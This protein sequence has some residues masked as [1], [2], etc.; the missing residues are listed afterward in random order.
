MKGLVA[1]VT[2]AAGSLGRA[3]VNKFI[4]DGMKVV[5]FDIQPYVENPLHDESAYLRSHYSENRREFDK[6]K[7]P[8]RTKQ[9]EK[10]ETLETLN[11]TEKS[12]NSLF[13]DFESKNIQGNRYFAREYFGK[14]NLSLNDASVE[15]S[16]VKESEAQSTSDNDDKPFFQGQNYDNCVEVNGD[17]TSSDNVTDAIDQ[18]FNEWGHLDVVVNCAAVASSLLS[19]NA[20][21]ESSLD[22]HLFKHVLDVNTKGTFNVIRLASE[23]MAENK[24]SETFGRGVIINTSSSFLS[25]RGGC[26]YASSCAGIDGMTLPISRDLAPLGIRVVTIA[27]GIFQSV[28]LSNKPPP[29]LLRFLH[30]LQL[31][32]KRMGQGHEYAHLVSAIINNQMLNGV[33]IKLDAGMRF[34]FE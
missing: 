12:E 9:Y 29:H 32:I 28:M 19:F 26:S 3:T 8:L 15:Q 17:V 33:T 18:A 27:P 30:Q 11:Q 34:P 22:L 24:I 31:S 23:A 21:S 4:A 1:L 25:D 10:L 2:G 6:I 16:P 7:V 5:A 20:L 13:E 14:D